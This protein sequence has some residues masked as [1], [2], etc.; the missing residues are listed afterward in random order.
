[1]YIGLPYII[2]ETLVINNEEELYSSIH[3]PFT[4]KSELPDSHIIRA[5]KLNTGKIAFETLDLPIGVVYHIGFDQKGNLYALERDYIYK[6]RKSHL[7]GNTSDL[8]EKIYES[9][10]GYGGGDRWGDHR[11]GSLWFGSD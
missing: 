4:S 3:A 2:I 8:W 10:L 7:E 6:F 5:S 1:M 11:G 9:F